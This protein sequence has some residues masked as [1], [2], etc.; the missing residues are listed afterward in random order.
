MLRRAAVSGQFY[1]DD[2]ESLRALVRDLM[3][4]SGPRRAAVGVLA[5]HAGY[6]YSG[7][8]AGT[9][10]ARIQVPQRVVILGP[11][12][13]GLGHPAALFAA[14]AWQT[15]LGEVPVDEAF[16]QALLHSCPHL[17]ADP[18]AHRHEHSLEVQVP[19]LQECNPELHIVP[20]C[21]GHLSLATLLAIGSCLGE[22]V[23]ADPEP[24][25]LVASSDMTH[26]EPGEVARRK[27]LRALDQVLR[28]DPEGL[29]RTVEADRT[30]MCGVLPATVL[31]AAANHLGC[32]RAELVRYGNSGDVTGDQREVVGYAGV[33]IWPPEQAG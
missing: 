11:N 31:L 21:L 29:L 16:A 13:H 18:E 24:T 7:T 12:H 25:L 5:P 10:F 6:V 4:E 32:R 8:I 17:A 19:F 1:P 30:S 23:A 20:L 26:Y 9:T 28:C 33:V 14:G 22:L 27:D 15:P 3:P 2:S